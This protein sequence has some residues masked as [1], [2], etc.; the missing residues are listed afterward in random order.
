MSNSNVAKQSY[1]G[2]VAE[3]ILMNILDTNF[4]HTLPDLPIND[5]T[6]DIN[7]E[8]YYNDYPVMIFPNPSSGFIRFEFDVPTPIET[9]YI[10]IVKV[11]NPTNYIVTDA[12]T[13]NNFSRIYDLSSQANGIYIMGININ[14][15][16]VTAKQFQ[17]EK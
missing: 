15:T 16:Y 9:A 10:T 6:P 12:F 2:A 8:Q 14:G 5:T 13:E 17:I 11:S 7:W 3:R 1:A 4:I